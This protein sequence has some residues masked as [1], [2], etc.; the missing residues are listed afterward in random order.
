MIAKAVTETSQWSGWCLA[1]ILP[2]PLISSQD[3]GKHDENLLFLLSKTMPC[4]NII[5]MLSLWR[6][7]ISTL[8]PRLDDAYGLISNDNVKSKHFWQHTLSYNSFLAFAHLG[9]NVNFLPNAIYCFQVSNNVYYGIGHTQ[10]KHW[11]W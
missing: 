3:A 2:M 5:I 7:N 4:W 9:V 10:L 1:Y 11:Q 8:H 6:S